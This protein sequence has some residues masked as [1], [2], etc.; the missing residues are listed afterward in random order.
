MAEPQAK[1]SSS[2]GPYHSK[3][4][5]TQLTN[6]WEPAACW[7]LCWVFRD[8]GAALTELTV[9]I[10][11]Q[12]RFQ[13]LWIFLHIALLQLVR[14]C[15]KEK[16]IIYFYLC[17]KYREEEAA[18]TNCFSGKVFISE[19]FIFWTIIH[20]NFSICHVHYRN[21][22]VLLLWEVQKKF[23]INN[24]YFCG[25]FM[26]TPIGRLCERYSKFGHVL[27]TWI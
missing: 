15:Y 6:V 1:Y 8:N 18:F 13:G 16:Q 23:I 19:N 4:E 21:V 10:Q 26:L 17:R 2:L 24:I 20:E 5:S 14:D 22:Y 11:D 3:T 25:L 27:H 12:L 9:Y 7:A